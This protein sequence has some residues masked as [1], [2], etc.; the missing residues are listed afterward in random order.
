MR[1]GMMGE[2]RLRYVTIPADA[3]TV[4]CPI[5]GDVIEIE[6][7]GTVYVPCPHLDH[8]DYLT[9]RS[10]GRYDVWFVER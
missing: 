6:E 5:C 4:T 9:P 10:D 8:D 2:K 3:D 7:D 1:G